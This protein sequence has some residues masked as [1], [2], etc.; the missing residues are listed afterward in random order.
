MKLT[1]LEKVLLPMFPN[2]IRFLAIHSPARVRKMLVW[3]D[4]V[5]YGRTQKIG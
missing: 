2:L 4:T 5:A 3:A 1:E